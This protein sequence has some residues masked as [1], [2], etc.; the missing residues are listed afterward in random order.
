MRIAVSCCC[1]CC[2]YAESAWESRCKDGRSSA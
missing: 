2:G 1:C